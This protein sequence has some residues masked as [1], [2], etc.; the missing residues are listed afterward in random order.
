MTVEIIKNHNSLNEGDKKQQEVIQSIGNELRSLNANIIE[1]A[2]WMTEEL[3]EQE[4]ENIVVF[5]ENNFDTIE[6]FIVQ[7]SA[8]WYWFSQQWAEK[9]ILEAKKMEDMLCP[10]VFERAAVTIEDIFIENL[11]GKRSWILQ[12]KPR[13]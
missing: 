7:W 4:I 10:Y 9:K 12:L 3:P 11:T 6:K 1:Q 13:I 8:D 2:K 5:C